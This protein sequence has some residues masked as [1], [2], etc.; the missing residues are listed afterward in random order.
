MIRNLV[1]AVIL[2]LGGLLL[3]TNDL[4]FSDRPSAPPIGQIKNTKGLVLGKAPAADSF[5]SLASQ[6]P[7]LGPLRIVTGFDSEADLL[8]G[9]PF[10]I[11]ENSSVHLYKRANKYFVEI[12]RGGIKRQAPS[13]QVEFQVNGQSKSGL[14]IF[15]PSD[16]KLVALKPVENQAANGA[17][18]AQPSTDFQDLIGNTLKLHQRFLEKCFIKLYEKQHGQ[19]QAGQVRTRFKINRKGHIDQVEILDSAFKDES[20]KSCVQE[21]ISRVQFKNYQDGVRTVEFPI[22]IQLPN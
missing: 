22:E 16:Q 7:L 4:R 12:I 21:V 11:L 19:I 9:E 17:I 10:K 13:K 8:F 14:E 15:A 3:F 2:I 6:S 5:S 1:V 20:F 18:T